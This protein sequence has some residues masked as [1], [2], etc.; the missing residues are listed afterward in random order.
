MPPLLA[1][2]CSDT[3]LTE[4]VLFIFF[5]ASEVISV[6]TILVSYM[7]IVHT[8]LQINSTEGRHKTFSTCASHLMAVTILHGTLI[9][10]D[11]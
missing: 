2:S 10:T 4:L 5:G 11:L 7:Y 1:I 9:F 6:L 3:F 8:I